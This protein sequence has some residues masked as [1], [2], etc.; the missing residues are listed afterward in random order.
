MFA[1]T[2][3]IRTRTINEN[4]SGLMNERKEEITRDPKFPLS[5]CTGIP[6]I[7]SRTGTINENGS[8]LMNERHYII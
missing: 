6:F 8:G 2:E 1:R 7:W 3:R 4:G 5:V